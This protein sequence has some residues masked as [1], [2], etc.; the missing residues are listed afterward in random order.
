MSHSSS[1][2]RAAF[3]GTNARSPSG[4][5]RGA[6]EP[7]TALV[8]L[9]IQLSSATTAEAAARVIAQVSDELLGWDAFYLALYHP[10][11]DT[12]RVV[13]FSDIVDGR[14]AEMPPS[15]HENHSGAPSA[16][17]RRTMDEGPVLL[18]PDEPALDLEAMRAFGDGNR[19][20]ASLMFV[21]VRS[22]N[23]MVGILSI[24][25]YMPNAYSEVE[26]QTLQM[27][28]DH[29]GGALERIAAQA[30][31]RDSEERFRILFEYSPDAIFLLDPHAPDAVWPIID[32]N[33]VACRMMGY[34]HAELDGR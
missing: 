31:Q 11:D 1:G 9:G 17:A 34:T 3:N 21:P 13:L 12:L 24:Q 27:L 6:S 29:C 7:H 16:I 14:R 15:A 2:S 8:Q 4:G 30:A 10:K 18:L 22:G 32:C 26:L 28:G 23:V 33:A 19:P 5:R 20:S 25:S